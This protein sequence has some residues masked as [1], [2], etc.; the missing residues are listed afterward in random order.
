[1][2]QKQTQQRATAEG[3][4]ATFIDG[5][6]KVEGGA[7][8]PPRAD[9]VRELSSEI[10]AAGDVD[11]KAADSAIW[12]SILGFRDWESGVDAWAPAAEH[13]EAVQHLHDRAVVF[14][15]SAGYLALAS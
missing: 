14:A 4:Q 1:M 11:R 3:I 10:C 7:D 8:Q 6:Y 2:S 13:R 15:P 9:M 5:A 12:E